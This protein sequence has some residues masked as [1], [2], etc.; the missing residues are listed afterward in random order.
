MEEGEV[1]GGRRPAAYISARAL[2]RRDPESFFYIIYIYTNQNV[3]PTTTLVR[4]NAYVFLDQT[5]G[6]RLQQR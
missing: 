2:A 4:E 6:W 5:F 1:D 3:I